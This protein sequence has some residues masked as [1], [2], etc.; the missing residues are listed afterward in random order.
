M[1]E[2]HSLSGSK[3]FKI[4][5]L[6]ILGLLLLAR[7]GYAHTHTL[8]LKHGILQGAIHIEPVQSIP[9]HEAGKIQPGTSVKIVVM[10]E[11]KG[12]QESPAG[13]LFVRYAFA[14]PLEHEESSVLFTTEKKPLPALEPGKKVDITFDA[15]HQIP[16][17]LDF[18]RYDWSIREYQAIAIINNEENLL[19]TL[20]ITFSAYYYPGFKKEFPTKVTH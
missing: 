9:G 11:N 3:R 15:V 14:H 4:A 7:I 2:N 19:G 10:V 20:A 6:G 18:V 5:A 16:S 17:L 13:E 1:S 8:D 12:L